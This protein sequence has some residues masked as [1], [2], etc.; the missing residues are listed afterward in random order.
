MWKKFW[1][2]A[3][4]LFGL[5]SATICL[6]FGVYLS[7]HAIT[8][9][10]DLCGKLIMVTS[11]TGFSLGFIAII[12][13]I[14]RYSFHGFTAGMISVILCGHSY[15]LLALVYGSSFLFQYGYPTLTFGILSVC[16]AL[17][18]KRFDIN[19][20]RINSKICVKF[21]VVFVLIILILGITFYMPQMVRFIG[22]PHVK[23]NLL[24]E[25]WYDG[26]VIT[27][28]FI[29]NRVT[30][31]GL[32]YKIEYTENGVTK[33]ADCGKVDTI[34]WRDLN[35]L[36]ENN[37]PANNI[38][39]WDVDLDGSLTAGDS[40]LIR[41]CIGKPGFTFR[42]ESYYV[43][44][45]GSVILSPDAPISFNITLDM[46]GN[47][48]TITDFG[49]DRTVIISENDPAFSAFPCLEKEL[50]LIG[51][52]VQNNNATL[53]HVLVEFYENNSYLGSVG[54][55]LCAGCR[56]RLIIQHLF[57]EEGVHNIVVKVFVFGWS[58]PII[59]NATITSIVPPPPPC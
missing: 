44:E 29:S 14:T 31:S 11:F 28:V 16:L 48:L 35:F 3:V 57:E 58:K 59:A 41:Y 39:F 51:V 50:V 37:L 1:L 49:E 34:Y 24:C 10:L 13:L 15:I 7:L 23:I 5:I 17:Y 21:L 55:P 12:F 8:Y 27:V 42:L 26:Y 53:Q 4:W 19:Q 22:P 54:K 45:G 9:G 30:V 43:L 46:P 20:L 33:T 52:T 56:E 32:L 38:S 6:L 47:K 36:L 40:F 2:I 18:I 25:Q